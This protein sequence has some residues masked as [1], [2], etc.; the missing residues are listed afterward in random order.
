MSMEKKK[1]DEKKQ[2]IFIGK[3]KRAIARARISP[4]KGTVKINGIPL[5]NIKDKMS[6]LKIQEPLILSGNAWKSANIKVTVRG[7]GPMGQAEAVR[8][9]VSRALVSVR[10]ELRNTYMNYDRFML[11]YDPRR[12]EPHKPPRSSQGPRKY[13]QRSKR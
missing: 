8:Q 3:R 9:A 4:G 12:T 2:E 7:G 5:D 10:P 1:R 6:R 11:V 13:K